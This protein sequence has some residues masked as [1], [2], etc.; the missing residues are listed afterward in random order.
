MLRNLQGI[1]LKSQR[2]IEAMRDAGKINY[3]AHMMMLDALKP[4]ISTGEL[5]R[6]A[7]RVLEKYGAVPAFLGYPPGGKYPFPAVITVSVNSELVHGIPS[8]ERILNDGDIVSLDC[9]TIYKGFVGD[10]AYTWPVGQIDGHLQQ[11]L[12]VTEQALNIG[13]DTSIADARLGDVSH[14]IQEYVQSFGY[15]VPKE[16]GGHG[17]GRNMHE[18]PHIPNWG[19]PGKGP[20]LRPGMTYA[21]EP[22]VMMGQPEL[23]VLAD[24][25]TVVTVD[26]KHAAHFEHTIAITSNGPDI[27]TR[28][29]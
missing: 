29:E 7:A 27:L 11:L 13:I 10:S 8:D 23:R 17:V 2:E 21:L 25:W 26:G 6:I 12:D 20:R 5:D 16:Y 28:P 22:M 9:G 4:G 3:E 15:S 19:I 1:V 18:D 24:H 14:A